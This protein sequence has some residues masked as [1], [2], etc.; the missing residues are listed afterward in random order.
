MSRDKCVFSD[1]QFRAC[2]FVEFYPRRVCVNLNLDSMLYRPIVNNSDKDS[3]RISSALKAIRNRDVFEPFSDDVDLDANVFSYVTGPAEFLSVVKMSIEGWRGLGRELSKHTS[4]DMVIKK[5]EKLMSSLHLGGR[6]AEDVLMVWAS[7]VT[8]KKLGVSGSDR[9]VSDYSWSVTDD[10]SNNFRHV[11]FDMMMNARCLVTVP[12]L[13]CGDVAPAHPFLGG[14]LLNVCFKCTNKISPFRNFV[15]AQCKARG[16]MPNY[17]YSSLLSLRRCR[18]YTAAADLGSVFSYPLSLY[19]SVL[20]NEDPLAIFLFSEIVRNVE[21]LIEGTP[22]VFI[23]DTVRQYLSAIDKVTFQCCSGSSSVCYI[24][25][26]LH[27]LA[28]MGGPRSWSKSQVLQ[29]IREW[30]SDKDISDVARPRDARELEDRLVSE[31]MSSWVRNT[32][33]SNKQSFDVFCTDLSKWATSGGGPKSVLSTGDGNVKLKT[34]WAWGFSALQRGVNVYEEARNLPH[35]A[36]VALKEEAKTRTVITTPMA[37]YLRQCYIL[38]VL[39]NPSFLDSTIGSTEHVQGLAPVRYRYYV[40]VDAS[41]F[42]HSVSKLFIRKLFSALRA[43]LTRYHLD[44]KLDVLI[45]DELE[46][47]DNLVV[48]FDGESIPYEGGLLSGWKWTSLIGSMK[49]DLLC[50]YINLR[51]GTRMKKI[52]QGDDIIM[53][54]DDVVSVEEV[55]A[56]CKDFGIVTNPLKTTVSDVGEFL[57]YRYGP[58][59]ISAYPARSV[60]S[61]FLA[62]PWLDASVSVTPGTLFQKWVTLSSRLSVCLN[63]TSV[64]KKCFSFGASDLVSWS[65]GSLT[66][67]MVQALLCTPSNA[68]G[69]GTVETMHMPKGANHEICY[70]SSSEKGLPH[71]KQFLVS[72]GIL[73]SPSSKR[74][75]V[76]TKRIAAVYLPDSEKIDW[77]KMDHVVNGFRLRPG[78]NTFKTLLALYLHHKHSD[79]LTSVYNN[80]IGMIDE[81]VFVNH[82]YPRYLRKTRDFLARIRYI[83]FPDTVTVPGSLYLDNRYSLRLTRH[84]ANTVRALMSA[85]RVLTLSRT[86]SLAMTV[87]REY[88]NFRTVIHSA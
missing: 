12:G 30:V 32:I 39:G 79:N 55:C 85:A 33:G 14:K 86:K 65:G 60:R 9:L 15:R 16:V 4:V 17:R 29:S 5:K 6:N 11:D 49:S 28:T 63:T 7:L 23:D 40:C 58:K 46:Q 84:F 37:S 3:G 56:I 35:L 61:I 62:N 70:I 50:E 88:L 66:R 68:G 53:M 42:D 21:L 31:W 59:V 38:Y 36:H 81:R 41:K 82:M 44:L 69:L 76:E 75:A 20:V 2:M 57:K 67:K 8:E 77:A 74:V 47:L 80:S 18:I 43:S 19:S 22:G 25:S 71:E 72:M 83:L 78:C 10:G 26:A 64:V 51:L 34:K 87:A 54:S 52:V 13:N 48:E 1:G 73:P 45:D 24:I 27:G